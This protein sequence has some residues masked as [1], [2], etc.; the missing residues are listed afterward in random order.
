MKLDLQNNQHVHCNVLIQKLTFKL[1]RISKILF[2]RILEMPPFIFFNWLPEVEKI[3]F[4]EAFSPHFE[5]QFLSIMILACYRAD[6]SAL[7][8]CC[9]CVLR[10]EWWDIHNNVS[11]PASPGAGRHNANDNVRGL[12]FHIPKF[13]RK[14]SDRHWHKNTLYVIFLIKFVVKILIQIE[15]EIWTIAWTF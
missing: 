2:G 10:V 9:V 8:I 1:Y 6:W 3:R 14:L 5:R 7:L 4:P 13:V 12:W 11:L 15:M